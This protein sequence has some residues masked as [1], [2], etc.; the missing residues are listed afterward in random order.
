M[1]NG[2]AKKI[3]LHD[4]KK[5]P[6][7]NILIKTADRQLE[8]NGYTEHAYRHLSLVAKMLP[9]YLKL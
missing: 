9:T 3:T 5:N 7:V 8:A 4:I 1:S 2:Q 6:E